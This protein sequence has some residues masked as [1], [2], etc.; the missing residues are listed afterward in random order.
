MKVID[1]IIFYNEL[2][3]LEYRLSILYPVV[4]HFV[5]CESTRTFVGNEKPLFFQE[6][7]ERFSR[8]ED[9][10][11]HVVIDDMIPDKHRAWDNE[12]RQRRSIDIGLSRLELTEKDLI[13]I[14]DCDEIP[15]PRIMASI[16]DLQGPCSLEMSLYYYHIECIS[17]KKWNLPK[18]VSYG[19]YSGNR[20]CEHIRHLKNIEIIPNAGWHLSYF[21]GAAMIRNKLMNFSHCELNEDRFTDLDKIRERIRSYRDLFDRS[22]DWEYV[23]LTK[24]PNPPV[25]HEDH[26]LFFSGHQG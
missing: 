19:Y 11:E 8:F 18:I 10:I 20:D 9:K 6:N 14:C 16:E 13:L 3:I 22:N 2:D 25:S 24:N 15:D 21:G 26:P 12:A 1:C 17:K 5:I 7:R 4:D 23:P